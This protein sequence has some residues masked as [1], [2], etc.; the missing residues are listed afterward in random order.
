MR[1]LC[2]ECGKQT[3]LPENV[4]EQVCF[5]CNSSDVGLEVENE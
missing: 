2:N 5:W 4:K 1:L 3:S